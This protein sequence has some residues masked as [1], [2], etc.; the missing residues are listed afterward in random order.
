MFEYI[1]AIVTFSSTV[2]NHRLC[3]KHL[4]LCAQV[5]DWGHMT[6][7]DLAI[8]HALPSDHPAEV[9]WVVPSFFTI[10]RKGVSPFFQIFCVFC[11]FCMITWGKL[12]MIT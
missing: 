12:C 10:I 11:A 6:R 2:V 3:P 9:I 1:I 7:V 5:G 4:S 8:S